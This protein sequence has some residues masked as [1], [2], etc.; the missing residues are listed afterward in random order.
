MPTLTPR[1]CLIFVASLKFIGTEEEKLNKV[2][3]MIKKFKLE[4]C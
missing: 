1:E 3:E 2:D 4:K